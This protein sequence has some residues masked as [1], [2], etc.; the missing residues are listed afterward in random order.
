[1]NLPNK[2]TMMRVIMVPFFMVFAA[3]SHMG[4]P[5]FNATYA[6]IAGILFAVGQL[7]GFPGWLPGPQEPPGNGLWQVY[8]P[9]G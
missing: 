3:M 7:Y 1:M 8:G 5:Q 9:A 4:T 6:L 2:L